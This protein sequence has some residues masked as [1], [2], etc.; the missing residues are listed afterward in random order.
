MFW[1]NV[2]LYSILYILVRMLL[3]MNISLVLYLQFCFSANMSFIITGEISLMIYTFLLPKF[4]HSY[5][6]L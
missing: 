6:V 4:E 2:G 3:V 5:G 1:C